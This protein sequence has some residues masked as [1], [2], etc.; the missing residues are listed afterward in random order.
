MLKR[1][2]AAAGVAALLAAASLAQEA[3]SGI[4][5]PVTASFGAMDT[6]RFNYFSPTASP[7]AA[8]FRLMFYPTLGWGT[9]G[10]P[11]RPFRSAA[12]HIFIT[13]LSSP[14]EV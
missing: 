7:A 1:F 12:C 6:H 4:S 2:L 5:M 9:T 14:K 8:N 3:E 10:L 13:M 11:M